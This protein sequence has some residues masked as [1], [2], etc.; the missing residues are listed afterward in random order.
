MATLTNLTNK[1][2]FFILWC[3]IAPVLFE[4]AFCL[5]LWLRKVPPLTSGFVSLMLVML[6]IDQMTMGFGAAV[7]ATGRIALFQL[8]VSIV[9][10][11]LIPVGYFLLRAGMPPYSILW[12]GIAG[13]TMAGCIR[14]GIAKKIAGLS[15]SDWLW[16]VGRP[17]VATVLCCC[18]SVAPFLFFMKGGVIRFIL[19]ILVNAVVA[20]SVMW[21]LGVTKE[22]QTRL[23]A[24]ANNSLL[25]VRGRLA[26]A[27]RT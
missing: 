26:L 19:V 18:V 5:G 22:H 9:N 11:L 24:T 12:I 2:A 17:L 15:I 20:C 27:G 16:D 7:Q 14:I 4:T 10:C 25:R 8:S 13:S 1:Y 6:L 3:V 21:R 23:I